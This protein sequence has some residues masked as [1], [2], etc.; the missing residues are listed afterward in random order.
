MKS[1]DK[2]KLWVE[3]LKNP[4]DSLRE[5]IIVEYAPLVKIIAGRLSIYRFRFQHSCRKA[6]DRD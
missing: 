5:Q 1:V 2:E 3:Y 4:T 6:A